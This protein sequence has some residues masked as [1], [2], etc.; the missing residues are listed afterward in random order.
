VGFLLVIFSCRPED[1]KIEEELSQLREEIKQI[2]EKVDYL[3]DR[4]AIIESEVTELEG[5]EIEIL[6]EPVPPQDYL[7]ILKFNKGESLNYEWRLTLDISVKGYYAPGDAEAEIEGS[8]KMD[9]VDIKPEW[10]QIELVPQEVKITGIETTYARDTQ[11]E[12]EMV[13]KMKEDVRFKTDKLGKVWDIDNP[14]SYCAILNNIPFLV[15]RR[16]RVGEKWEIKRKE[17]RL[18]GFLGLTGEEVLKGDFTGSVEFLR[19]EKKGN[20]TIAI[21]EILGSMDTKGTKLLPTGELTLKERIGINIDTG[22]IISKNT[23]I[24]ME[25]SD[26]S[27]TVTISLDI[28]TTL[29]D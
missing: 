3:C 6:P 16:V 28:E 9:V 1:K 8:Y 29:V 21:L 13:D 24:D 20:Y 25:M 19:V 7:I 22:R 27:T 5:E 15:D 23:E 11:L 14:A 17:H 10:V 18:Q 12:K 4:L 2:S 26:P